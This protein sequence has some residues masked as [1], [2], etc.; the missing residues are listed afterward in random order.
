MKTDLYQFIYWYKCKCLPKTHNSV[1]H[2]L[3]MPRITLYPFLLGTEGCVTHMKKWCKSCTRVLLHRTEPAVPDGWT[4]CKKL[5]PLK[6]GPNMTEFWSYLKTAG[7]A[8]SSLENMQY[9]YAA[10]QKA[11]LNFVLRAFWIYTARIYT[12]SFWPTVTK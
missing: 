4:Q 2:G 1:P 8:C 12:L 7:K 6:K 11:T 9:Q 3:R 5:F 10:I